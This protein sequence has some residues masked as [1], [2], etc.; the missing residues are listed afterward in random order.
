VD[1]PSLLAELIRH[2][3]DNPGG[4]EVALCRY[5]ERALRDRGADEVT[6][7]E[8]PR[9]EHGKARGGYVF[10][11]WGEPR[12]LINTHI[13]TVPANS[14]WTVDPW[15]GVITDDRVVGLGA[16]DTKGA[17]AS[18][19]VAL[20]TNKPRDLGV[21]FSGDE[22][23]NGT[24]VHHF[25]ASPWARA[26]QR[27]IVCEPTGRA[28]GVRHRGVV[29]VEAHVQGQGGHSSGADRMPRPIVTM[30][31]LAVELD[32][33]GARWIDRGPEDMRGLCMNVASI[34]GGVAFNVV[35]DRA[36]LTFSVRP[37]PGFDAQGF[38]AELAESARRAG[39]G[40][41]TQAVLERLPFATRDI[42]PFRALLGAHPRAE[43]TLPFWTEAAEM[44]QAGID[45]VVIGPG[46]IAQ[47]HAP[48]EFVTK[49]DLAWAVDLFANVIQKARERS[50]L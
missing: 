21:L 7:V 9:D 2:R 5:L 17:I 31:R 34:G 44:S 40:V 12:T 20:E 29:A 43:A 32:A 22:E 11:R 50:L 15:A 49:S 6:V 41:R 3:T 33:L 47:A 19:L 27:A 38:A 4:D 37:P 14:G 26:I 16:A 28:V 18:A 25:L 42:E 1:A 45:A 13:D 8:V 48:D 30:A 36:S 10:A 24:C 39:E 46:D 35:P 23:V